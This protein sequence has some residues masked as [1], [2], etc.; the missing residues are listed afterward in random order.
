MNLNYISSSPVLAASN[1]LNFNLDDYPV[2]L[3]ESDVDTTMREGGQRKVEA[4]PIVEPT[5]QQQEGEMEE[6][7]LLGFRALL[8]YDDGDADDDDNAP[9]PHDDLAWCEFICYIYVR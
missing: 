6:D 7:P 5:D 3:D 1:L 4:E 8:G 2:D 9:L